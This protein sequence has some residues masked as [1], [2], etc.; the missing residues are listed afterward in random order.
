VLR[1]YDTAIGSVEPLELRQPGELSMYI[2]GP[3]VY[4]EPHAGHGR[5]CLVWDMLRRYAEWQGLK[6]HHVSNVTDIDDKIINRAKAERTTEPEV[7]ATW[8]AAWWDAMGRL[9][10]ARPHE[11]PHAT[12]YVGRMVTFIAELVDRGKAYVGGDGVY[13]SSETVE[14]YGLLPHRTIDVLSSGETRLE[15]GDESGKRSPM[16][17]VLWKFAKPGEPTWDAPWGAGRPGWHTECVVMSVD[18]LGDSFDVHGG[19][20]DLI[21]P[22]HEDERAQ[23]VAAGERFSRRWVHHEMVVTEGGVKM[24][25]SLGNFLSLPDLLARYD[26][27][28]Y[29]LL[30]LQTHYRKTM[31]VSDTTMTAA[32]RTLEG[33]DA[34]ARDFAAARGAPADPA[35]LDRFRDRMDDDLDAPGA[36]ADLFIAQR[37]AR[38]TGNE[39]IAAAVF[40][41]WESGLGLSLDEGSGQIPPEAQAKAAERDEARAAR[42]WSRADRLR[43]ELVADGYVVEDTP[44]GT[45]LRR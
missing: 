17:F 41:L 45:R 40:E 5:A 29:R 13:F 8:E 1:L 38:A 16:D 35:V 14:D 4:G 6:V 22:H 30:A 15:G 37:E 25:K 31:T 28:A 7:A 44:E 33:L 2:C 26:Q 36:V 19:G 3:T 24:S 21:F 10:I 18:L 9:G 42:D 11:T 20:I 32:T 23:A 27:R 39:A 12:D 43:N 34:F